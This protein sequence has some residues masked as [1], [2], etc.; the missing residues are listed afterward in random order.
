MSSKIK[1]DFTGANK[2]FAKKLTKFDGDIT[3]FLTYLDQTNIVEVTYQDA[4]N[5]S[6]EASITGFGASSVSLSGANLEISENGI[7]GTVYSIGVDSAKYGYIEISNAELNIGNHFVSELKSLYLSEDFFGTEFSDTIFGAEG[8]D[9]LR[10]K[11]GNDVLNGGDGK[12]KLVGGNGNDQLK[13]GAKDDL[14]NGGIGND[15]LVGGEGSDTLIGG[16]GKDKLIGGLGFDT[17]TGGNG[18]DIFDLRAEIT[19]QNTFDTITDYESKDKIKLT[20]GLTEN[21]LKIKQVGGNVKIKYEHDLLAIVQNTAADN[22]NFIF[23]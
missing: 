9:Y 5:F 12:D 4:N 13:G 6:A 7:S 18:K 14:L 3:T 23:G 1:Y 21:D 11:G 20:D 16:D 8:K 17:L 22:L 10:G 19:G 15:K 2:K